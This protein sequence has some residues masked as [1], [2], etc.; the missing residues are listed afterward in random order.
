MANASEA[1]L[2]YV[3]ET[4]LGTTPAAALTELRFTSEGLKKVTAA[5]QSNEI[6]ADRRNN[7]E[8]RNSG[9]AVQ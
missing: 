3:N 8:I 2:Y 9:K 1:Q 7:Q 5:Q 6:R 4:V